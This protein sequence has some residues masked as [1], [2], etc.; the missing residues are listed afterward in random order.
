M[1]SYRGLHHMFKDSSKNYVTVCGEKYDFKQ[2]IRD[3]DI[4]FEI[5]EMVT[6]KSYKELG[7]G[8]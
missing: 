2:N 7:V 4:Y 8:L 1:N 3:R 5:P 6:L